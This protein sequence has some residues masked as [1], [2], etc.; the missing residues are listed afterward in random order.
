[1]LVAAAVVATTLARPNEARAQNVADLDPHIRV[2]AA[3]M[4]SPVITLRWNAST[5]A[6]SFIVRRREAAT[7]AFAMVAMLPAT[8][9]SYEDR[10]VMVGRTYEYAV[11][12]RSMTGATIANGEAYVIAGVDV[13]FRDDPG[14]VAVVVDDMTLA[15]QM[16]KL[17]RFED[18]LRAD[19]WSVERVVV[20]RTDPPP[21]V[22]AALQRVV[23]THGARFEAAVLIGAVPR[24]FSGNIRPDGHADHEGAWPADGYYADLDGVWT[25][26]RDYGGTNFNANRAGD[27]KF[28]PSTFPS[29]LDIAVGR[30][31][32]EGMTAFSAM[33]TDLIGRYLDRNHAYRV[34]EYAPRPRTWVSDSFGYF[35]SEAFSRVAWRDGNVLFGADPESGRPFFD[36]LEDPAGGYAFAFGCGG[37]N[38]QGAG[39]VGSTT[40]FVRRMPRAVFVGLFGSYFG[41]WAYANNFLRAPLF[42]QSGGLASLWF[43]RPWA[44]LHGLGAM[45]SFGDEFLRTVQGNGYD[46]GF[47]RSGVHQ[48]LM[49]DPTLRMFTVRPPTMLR[50]TAGMDGVS[51]TWGPSPESGL[52]GYHVYRVRASMADREAA[53]RLTMAPVTATTFIDRTAMAGVEQR[54]RVV[55]VARTTTGSGI[56]QNHSLGVSALAT[57]IAPPLD[58]GVATDSGTDSGSMMGSD[59]ASDATLDS[60]I[61]SGPDADTDGG[62]DSGIVSSS[63]GSTPPDTGLATVDATTDGSNG[64]AAM[65]GCGCS[66]PTRSNATARGALLALL[67][68]AA[69]SARRSRHA[70]DR[71]DG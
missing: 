37:G 6:Q 44:H 18:D 10:T 40:D 7:D 15:A 62:F 27:G 8:A 46:I 30:V 38:P 21:M 66:T 42:G 33:P 5:V 56:Y 58:A 24:A 2:T 52:A 14:A 47:S 1:M 29:P 12:R 17:V 35:S 55:A 57:P 20:R 25:D 49:G 13:A 60:G 11:Q 54:Y 19:G 48:G 68:V 22:R 64:P 63:D 34:G 41:D 67:A 31:D 23:M 26:T 3:A 45:R 51:L 71:S 59:G 36:A 61:G 16:M 39:G 70:R 50:A 69:V 4:P 65:A 28:D 9:T 43:A 53:V 32:A